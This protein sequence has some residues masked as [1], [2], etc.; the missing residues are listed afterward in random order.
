[1]SESEIASQILQRPAIEI[2]KQ[3]VSGF[4][5]NK[6]I[7]ITGAAGSIG[8]E[9]VKQVANFNPASIILFDNNENGIFF[10]ERE[11]KEKFPNIKVIA[12]IGSICN[13]GRIHDLFFELKPE[14]VYHA[15][16]HKHVSIAE[17]N[18]AQTIYN[19][20]YGTRVVA[21]A[22]AAYGCQAFVMISTD[23]SVN[24]TTILGASKRICEYWIQHMNANYD[25]KFITVRFGNVLGSAGSVIPVFKKQIESG[26]PITVTDKDVTR[27]FMTIP[28]AAI[29]T[30]QASSIGNGGE[31]FVLDMGEPV[32]II[33]LAYKM[34]EL[35]GLSQSDI[36]INFSGLK[37]G[38][39]LNEELFFNDEIQTPTKYPKINVTKN[40]FVIK[41]IQDEILHLE[42]LSKN[43]TEIVIRKLLNKIIPGAKV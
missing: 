38:E 22:A 21:K 26:G 23:K 2:N 7:L 3:D 34:I 29:L 24:P 18:V 40:T 31:I 35:Y 42:F 6:N 16:A 41:N 12:R 17:Q 43:S 30:I 28:E 13:K 32:K 5:E 33:D 20:V 25:T 9:L 36:K 8:S 19:N 15:A 4:L 39:K 1:M 10:L 11:I 14:I 27:F 37:Q